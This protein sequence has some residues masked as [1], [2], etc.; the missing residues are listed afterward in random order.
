MSDTLRLRLANERCRYGFTLGRIR[1]CP[2]LA[3]TFATAALFNPRSPTD[4]KKV[5]I[6]ILATTLAGAVCAQ[7]SVTLYG[8]IDASI[9]SQKT[10]VGGV[11]TVDNG[12]QIRSGAHTGSRWGLKGSEDLGGGLKANFQLEQGFNIDVGTASSPRQFH[13]QAWAG[14]SGGFGS[15]RLGRQYSPIDNLYT[16]HDT[17]AL[18]GYSAVGYAFNAGAYA[19]SSRIDNA[20]YYSTPSVMGGLSAAVMWAPGENKNGAVGTRKNL[21][22]LQAIYEAGPLSVG[23][24]YEAQRFNGLADT[25]AWDLG[26]S[27]DFGPAK[28]YGQLE[29]AKN[30]ATNGKDSG[31]Q[32]GVKI[33]LGAPL[34]MVSYARENF[35]VAGAKVSTASAYSLMAQYP[36]S[37]RTYVYAAYLRGTTDPVVGATTRQRNYGLGLVH[38]F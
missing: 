32:I 7:S 20:V 9:A 11:T 14:L 35:K 26:T 23:G 15:V 1:I 34:V 8:R 16:E 28:L 38:N 24:A 19:D 10:E 17:Y 5:L 36:L 25:T 18:S 3:S 2:A 6:P 30:K 21:T 33:P 12:A 27:Y 13:R 29:G 4:M 22:G 31:Y 37:K